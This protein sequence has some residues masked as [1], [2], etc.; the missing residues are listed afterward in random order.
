VKSSLAAW[1]ERRWIVLPAL[2]F[3]VANLVFFLAGRAVDASRQASLEESRKTAAE[4]AQAASK[5]LDQAREAKAHIASVEAAAR[6]FY[7]ARIGTVNATMAATVEEIHQVCRRARVTPHQI[8]YSVAAI[9]DTP[10]T[11]MSIDFSVEGNYQTLR[12]LVRGF[13]EDPRWLVVRAVDLARR[14]ETVGEGDVHLQV[15]T[16]FSKP[17]GERAG[18]VVAREER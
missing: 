16:Y 4:A 18:V 1:R 3:F 11:Q 9:P 7:G 17:A 2:A 5:E 10:L 12:Q 15:A 13:E 8:S 14:S 6:E